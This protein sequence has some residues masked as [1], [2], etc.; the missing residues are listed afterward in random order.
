LSLISVRLVPLV[1]ALPRHPALGSRD[2]ALSGALG[3]WRRPGEDARGRPG[4][5]PTRS[6]TP[7]RPAEPGSTSRPH[8]PQTCRD[9][10]WPY[11]GPE[12]R[13]D[14]PPGA[15]RGR[16]GAKRGRWTSPAGTVRWHR[17]PGH[18]GHVRAGYQHTS[19]VDGAG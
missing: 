10:L 17:R 4:P 9:M 15:H 12:I 19:P 16:S 1:H 7:L 13:P 5:R 18:Q 6:T 8:G 3:R 11:C 14:P 2:A